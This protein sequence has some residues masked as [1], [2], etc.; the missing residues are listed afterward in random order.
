MISDAIG[1]VIIEV[2][3]GFTGLIDLRE[4]FLGD[5]TTKYRQKTGRDN[6]NSKNILLLTGAERTTMFI[7]TNS[8]PNITKDILEVI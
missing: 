8:K 5:K 2:I 7:V 6:R 3:D 4:A 1:D